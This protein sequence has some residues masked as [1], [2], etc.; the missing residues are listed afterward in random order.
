MNVGHI[1][2]SLIFMYISAGQI[3]KLNYLLFRQESYLSN[4]YF[5]WPC[6]GINLI[7]QFTYSSSYYHT[8]ACFSTVEC[9]YCKSSQMGIITNLDGRDYLNITCDDYFLYVYL[10]FV[11]IGAL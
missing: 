9:G 7:L 5:N 4:C 2:F 6:Y 11:R 8:T 3:K 1:L 10:E